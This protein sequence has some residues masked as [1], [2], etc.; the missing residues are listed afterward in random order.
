M[1]KLRSPFGPVAGSI[2]LAL[3]LTL[4]GCSA[5]GGG[6]S[7]PST[8]SQSA[9]SPSPVSSSAVPTST[10]PVQPSRTPDCTDTRS[11]G[12]APQ[13]VEK[14]GPGPVIYVVLDSKESPCWYRLDFALGS[15]A[16][17]GYRAQ[18][19][20]RDEVVSDAQG[21]PVPNVVGAAFLRVAILAPTDALQTGG[22]DPKTKKPILRYPNIGDPVIAPQEPGSTSE[23]RG[24]WFAGTF[25]G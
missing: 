1:R 16:R 15:N 8:T 7:G 18:Y 12:T 20:N 5:S 13:R 21:E 9:V 19:V 4:A 3:V 10:P 25:E 23:I 2:G 24:I 14:L 6:T 11:W 22:I 17:V